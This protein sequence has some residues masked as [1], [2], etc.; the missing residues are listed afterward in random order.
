MIEFYGME[1]W[2]WNCFSINNRKSKIALENNKETLSEVNY[3]I[4]CKTL[5]NISEIIYY[6]LKNVFNPSRKTYLKWFLK[7]F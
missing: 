1:K 5:G 2:Y 4:V 3:K 7:Y 6:K